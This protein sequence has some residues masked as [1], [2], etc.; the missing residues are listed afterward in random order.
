M[1]CQLIVL[2]KRVVSEGR[3]R[4]RRH[5]DPRPLPPR[6]VA[7]AERWFEDDEQ[8]Q[9]A[10]HERVEGGVGRFMEA[11]R[12]LISFRQPLR[13]SGTIYCLEGLHFNLLML[14]SRT[15]FMRAAGKS[16]RRIAFRDQAIQ[17]CAPLLRRSDPAFQ[18]DYITAEQTRR[19]ASVAGPNR[20][21]AHPWKID[22]EWF[23]PAESGVGGSAG[24]PALLAGNMFR[25]EGIVPGL[26]DA[27]V[28]I[29]RIGRHSSLG[30][31]F[32]F[33]QANPL[34]SLSVNTPH[35][36]YLR[37]LQAASVLLLPITRCDEPAGLTAAME[38]MAAGV[39]IL[40]NHSMGIAEL[41]AEC[42]YPLPMLTDL[43]PVSWVAGIE[44]LS[45]VRQSGVFREALTR[46][47]QCLIDRRRIL[48]D[49]GDWEEILAEGASR[50]QRALETATRK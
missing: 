46:A 47:R 18:F 23:Q 42:D 1:A 36:A 33:L 26:L 48:P 44:E 49:A 38:A 24:G 50:K 5:L 29:Q 20:V 34:F 31:S 40:A 39:P 30:A 6:S 41:F 28:R 10:G 45:R 12:L 27:G 11:L 19:A 8:M 21:R 15:P 13:E 2:A 9:I 17:L 43:S 14:L 37:H 7:A 16:I 22:T 25:D 35:R 32:Q 4:P 3:E